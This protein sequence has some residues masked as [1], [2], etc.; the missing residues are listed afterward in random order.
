MDEDKIKRRAEQT[1][2]TVKAR[3]EGY[4]RNPVPHQKMHEDLMENGISK[5]TKGNGTV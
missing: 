1:A 2:R 4:G 5:G 3:A